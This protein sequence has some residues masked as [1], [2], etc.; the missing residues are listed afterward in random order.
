MKQFHITGK[1][2]SVFRNNPSASRYLHLTKCIEFIAPRLAQFGVVTVMPFEGASADIAICADGGM[3][4][5]KLI[6]IKSST[7]GWRKVPDHS[8]RKWKAVTCLL[9]QLDRESLEI[10]PGRAKMRLAGA[11]DF[12]DLTLDEALIA[13]IESDVPTFRR[14]QALRFGLPRENEKAFEEFRSIKGFFVG[15][16]C[17]YDMYPV[18]SVGVDS[19]LG[20]PGCQSCFV[21]EKTSYY[22]RRR[23]D[24]GQYCNLSLTKYA[25]EVDVFIVR[26]R[27]PSVALRLADPNDAPCEWTGIFGYVDAFLEGIVQFYAYP[28]P[29]LALP[30]K[31]GKNVRFNTSHVVWI[32]DSW[33]QRL[34]FS[35]FQQVREMVRRNLES[36]SKMRTRR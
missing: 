33:D 3:D 20:M 31:T 11:S 21:Q 34:K 5:T 14:E 9:V 35:S 26:S 15:H 23:R 8:S 19:I 7:Y 25:T 24:R 10:R 17:S 1:P 4:A 27:C 12:Q 16:G 32:H 2:D 18:K 29:A 36:S 22:G 28:P 13:I 30:G 6:D